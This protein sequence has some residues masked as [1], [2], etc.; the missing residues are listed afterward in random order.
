MGEEEFY[1]QAN[2]LRGM[3]NSL[4]QSPV[5]R[6]LCVVEEGYTPTLQDLTWC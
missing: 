1:A 5:A 3:L 2:L 6:L 4:S